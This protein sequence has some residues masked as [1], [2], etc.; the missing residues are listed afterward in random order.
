[1]QTS[2]TGIDKKS[3]VLS[4][5]IWPVVIGVFIAGFLALSAFSSRIQLSH[6]KTYDKI[7]ISMPRKEA[8]KILLA[9]PLECG[10]TEPSEN[11]HICRFSDPWHFY[12]ISVDATTERVARKDM[13]S[14]GPIGLQDLLRK[15]PKK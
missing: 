7:Y 4:R 15:S 14:R 3:S 11:A 9:E 13:L 5:S 2:T 1:M 6:D 10:L 12:S 8:V